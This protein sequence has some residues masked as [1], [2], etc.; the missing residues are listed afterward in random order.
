MY[1][2]RLWSAGRLLKQNYAVD[3]WGYYDEDPA[4]TRLEQAIEAGREDGLSANRS[5]STDGGRVDVAGGAVAVPDGSYDVDIPEPAR[6]R[7]RWEGFHSGV[8]PLIGAC[9]V[10]FVT[11]EKQYLDWTLSN[12]IG[13]R[14]PF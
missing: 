10:S 11:S 7:S 12:G 4:F 13:I 1:R 14:T 6:Y 5:L 8:V 3:P 2:L 9:E